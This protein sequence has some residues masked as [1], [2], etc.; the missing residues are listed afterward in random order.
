MPGNAKDG[1]DKPV[2]KHEENARTELIRDCVFVYN[3]LWSLTD[4]P[5][6]AALQR[7]IDGKPL[8]EVGEQYAAFRIKLEHVAEYQDRMLA[9]RVHLDN[10]LAE[11]PVELV[12]PSNPL[13]TIAQW[14][15]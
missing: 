7:A 2:A 14:G 1:L 8:A 6:L 9:I 12:I 3:E 13:V 15:I 11:S 10:L 5:Q 4:Y